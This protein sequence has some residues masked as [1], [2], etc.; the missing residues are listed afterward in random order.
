VKWHSVDPGLNLF[1]PQLLRDSKIAVVTALAPGRYRL[2]AISAKG[3]QPS[4]FAQCVIIIGDAPPVTV[5]PDP[6]PGPAPVPIAGMRVLILYESDTPLPPKTYDAIF[7]T[8][9]ENYLRSKCL[10][11]PDLKT[12]ERRRFDEDVSLGAMSKAWQ[13]LR[14][15][16]PSQ[17][18]IGSD[19]FPIPHVAI[20]DSSGAVVYSG[21]FP[22][23]EAAALAL[24]KKYG[25]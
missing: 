11:G 16:L 15:K 9:L 3:D 20:G 13:D 17:L 6:P 2:L 10:V 23:D 14:S 18:P 1:P 19:G 8:E 22:A 5:P 4:D 7:S 24:F 21:P 25:G 12:P